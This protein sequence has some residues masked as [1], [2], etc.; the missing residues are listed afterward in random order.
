MSETE[1]DPYA[2]RD[3][4]ML[5][6]PKNFLGRIKYLGPSLIITGAAVGSGEG[7]P[8]Q[9]TC[10]GWKER[11][12]ELELITGGGVRNLDDLLALKKAGVDGV[13]IASALHDGSLG[14]AELERLSQ[15]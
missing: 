10:L 5:A 11:F 15:S 13:L 14:R 2:V 7:P 3:E 4:K 9:E 12:P 6:P 1:I 8:H